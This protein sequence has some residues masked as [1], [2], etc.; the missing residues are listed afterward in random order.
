MQMYVYITYVSSKQHAFRNV[1]ANLFRI[2]FKSLAYQDQLFRVRILDR[3]SQHDSRAE[4]LS[5]EKRSRRSKPA[6]GNYRDR[7]TVEIVEL[8]P[9]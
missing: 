1:D 5:H 2:N 7:K 3:R 6:G 4:L 9:E 8:D